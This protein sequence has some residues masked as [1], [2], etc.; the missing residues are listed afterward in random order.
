M[1]VY[2]FEVTN[3]PSGYNE[4]VVP[5]LMARKL[6]IEEPLAKIMLFKADK[7]GVV[8]PIFKV[9]FPDDRSE[10]GSFESLKDLPESTSNLGTRWAKEDLLVDLVFEFQR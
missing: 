5:S 10:V 4:Q 9:Y 3:R 8:K 1:D 6:S 7:A 2:L